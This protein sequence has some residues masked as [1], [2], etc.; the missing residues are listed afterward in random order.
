[1][2]LVCDNACIQSKDEQYLA[3]IVEPNQCVKATIHQFAIQSA[4][5][6]KLPK[7]APLLRDPTPWT[8]VIKIRANSEIQHHGLTLSPVCI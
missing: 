7:T 4:E 5:R 2:V 8:K 3:Q 6:R 1:M